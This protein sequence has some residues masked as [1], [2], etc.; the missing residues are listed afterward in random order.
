MLG[1][2]LLLVF[3][4]LS[5][6]SNTFPFKNFYW[7]EADTS[8]IPGAW[9]T[10]RWT[11]WGIQNANNFTQHLNSP[12]T[13]ISPVNNWSTRRNVPQKFISSQDTFYYLSRFSFVFFLIALAFTGFALIVDLLGLCWEVIDKIVVLLVLIALF[14]QAGGVAFQTAVVVMAKDA[15][16]NDNRYAHVPVALM[17]IVWTAFVCLGLVWL[18]TTFATISQSWSNHLARV[19]A[20]KEAQA[21]YPQQGAPEGGIVAPG[22]NDQSSFTRSAPAEVE[23]EHSN[24]GIRFFRVKKSH[25]TSDEESV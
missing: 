16:N 10:T 21:G 18:N 3:T 6:V 23:K 4:V 22:M 11:F 8:G 9:D 2:V 14:F 5:G 13:P 20:N 7:I 24:G 1:V 19:R 17:A 12:A 15:F 25:K